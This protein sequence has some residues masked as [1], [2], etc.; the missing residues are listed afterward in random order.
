MAMF[1]TDW[2][3]PN[4]YDLVLNMGKMRRDR[5][6][7]DTGNRSEKTRSRFS[8]NAAA[9]VIQPTSKGALSPRNLLVMIIAAAC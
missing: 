1:G 5:T 4:R 7:V 8:I 9:E 2:R 3:D 6:L